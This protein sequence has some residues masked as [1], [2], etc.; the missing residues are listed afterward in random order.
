MLVRWRCLLSIRTSYRTGDNK[1][2][3]VGMGI[4]WIYGTERMKVATSV[5]LPALHFG[6]ILC[7]HYMDYIWIYLTGELSNVYLGVLSAQVCWGKISTLQK[8]LESISNFAWYLCSHTTHSFFIPERSLMSCWSLVVLKQSIRWVHRHDTIPLSRPSSLLGERQLRWNHVFRFRHG[9]SWYQNDDR[10]LHPGDGFA[11]LDNLHE[12]AGGD[13]LRSLRPAPCHGGHAT[14]SSCLRR[15]NRGGDM[16]A[17]M[18]RRC[19]T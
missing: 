14:T 5:G 4:V 12:D 16:R 19:D 7:L 2:G 10:F 18:V 8:S 9:S 1:I 11:N 15:M 13:H 6:T 17:F 3:N